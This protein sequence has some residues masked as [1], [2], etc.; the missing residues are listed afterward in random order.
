MSEKQKT[1]AAPAMVSGNGLHTGLNV[2][3]R[4]LPAP[5][6]HGI[7]FKRVDVDGKPVVDA[8]C[9]FVL[10]TN[11][12]TTIGY[13]GAEVGTIEHVMAAIIGMG[14]DNL[15]V[16]ADNFEMPIKDGSSKFFTEAIQKAGVIELDE[17]KGFVLDKVLI[18]R[19]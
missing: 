12:G 17:K 14:I 11:R 10:D 1:I 7:K 4:F 2:S 3:L 19:S 8:N 16:E 18:F 5:A 9:D 13:N 15:M 6:N